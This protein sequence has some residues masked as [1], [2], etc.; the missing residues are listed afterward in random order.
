MPSPTS[1]KFAS[2]ISISV[3]CSKLLVDLIVCFHR[4]AE[5]KIGVF[6]D[7]K[8]CP[9]PNGLDPASIYRNIKSALA[10]KGYHGEVTITPYCDTNQFPDGPDEFESAGM[11]LVPADETERCRTMSCDICFWFSLDRKD[12]Y[13]NVLVISGDNMDFLT[14]LEYFKQ[15]FPVNVFLAQPENSWR[16]CPKCRNV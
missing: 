3:S 10:K 1:S 6:W 8:E 15:K 9:I 12:K 4:L 13:T 11:K 14:P 16:W 5:A 7:V 2:K